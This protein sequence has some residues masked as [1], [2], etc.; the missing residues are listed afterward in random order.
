MS[1]TSLSTSNK[2]SAGRDILDDAAR[3][4]ATLAITHARAYIKVETTRSSRL[5]LLNPLLSSCE[6][7]TEIMGSNADTTDDDECRSS[8]SSGAQVLFRW[9]QPGSQRVAVSGEWCGWVRAQGV[10]VERFRS[11]LW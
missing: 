5:G 6:L 11:V 4:H 7:G 8:T 1:S 2:T 10:A 9:E 3:T